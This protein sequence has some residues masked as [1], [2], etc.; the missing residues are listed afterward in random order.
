MF[1]DPE[2]SVLQYLYFVLQ[3]SRSPGISLPPLHTQEQ[4][5]GCVREAKLSSGRDKEASNFR[6][7]YFRCVLGSGRIILGPIEY[8][9]KTCWGFG[10]PARK[11]EG[12][13]DT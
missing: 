6:D 10:L 9:V 3:A 13:G 12:T 8:A 11:L 5:D 2:D 1:D 7:T 4:Q